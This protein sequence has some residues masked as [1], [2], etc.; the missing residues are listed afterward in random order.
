[1]HTRLSI[2]VLA[3][4]LAACNG[5][6][7]TPE[8]ATRN[9]ARKVVKPIVESRIPGAPAGLTDCIID[10][11]ETYELVEIAKAAT[12]GPGEDTI[13][14]VLSIAQRPDTLR[15]AASALL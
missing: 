15:C 2:G 5:S 7:P 1:M 4:V 8:E 13:G 12:L 14:V 3:F 11:A 9:A 10:N 6:I